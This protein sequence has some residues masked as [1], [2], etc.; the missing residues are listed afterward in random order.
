VVAAKRKKALSSCSDAVQITA[1]RQIMK[2]CTVSALRKVRP[3]H[4]AKTG[5]R[6]ETPHGGP[7]P[8]H[9]QVDSQG[10]R[11]HRN[12]TRSFEDRQRGK[13]D[14]GATTGCPANSPTTKIHW[15]LAAQ[16][17]ACAVTST[18]TCALA[19][20]SQSLVMVNA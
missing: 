14:I 4:T 7:K 20:V 13:A 6:N 5:A 8:L 1:S 12:P 15:H 11:G 2:L 3:R 17:R 16:E 9:S 18:A 19:R 10:C